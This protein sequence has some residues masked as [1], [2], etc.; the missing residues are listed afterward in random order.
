MAKLT[1]PYI[2]ATGQEMVDAA[3]EALKELDTESYRY[4]VVPGELHN[5]AKL[6]EEQR[7]R[8][9]GIRQLREHEVVRQR[10][11]RAASREIRR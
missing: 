4:Y 10:R 5:I 6:L 3:M 1:T 11:C 2:Q 7:F 9:K 8:F